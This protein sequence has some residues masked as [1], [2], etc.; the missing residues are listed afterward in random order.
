VH[1]APEPTRIP[2]G[3]WTIWRVVDGQGEQGIHALPI[4]IS[5]LLHGQRW[6]LGT[7]RS[8]FRTVR[9]RCF[10]EVGLHSREAR[11]L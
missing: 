1:P 3:T 5:L 9:G 7:G 8:I 6:P 11:G 10:D 4:F 2:V